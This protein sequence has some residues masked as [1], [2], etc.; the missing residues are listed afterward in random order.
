M[1]DR[2]TDRQAKNNIPPIFRS[3]GIK[4][5]KISAMSKANLEEDGNEQIWS[6]PTALLLTRS[7]AVKETIARVITTKGPEPHTSL[8]VGLA[9]K[10]VAARVVINGMV[11]R[12]FS[13]RWDGAVIVIHNSRTFSNSPIMAADAYVSAT[14]ALGH[15]PEAPFM[16][17]HVV[18]VWL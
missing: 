4:R 10:T 3:G 16:S 9:D 18:S 6:L 17:P 7:A 1:N 12:N 8:I 13:L 5:L 11:M 14:S 2:Q 15:P